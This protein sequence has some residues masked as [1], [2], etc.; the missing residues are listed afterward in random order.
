MLGT[1]PY[2]GSSRLEITEY[3][4]VWIRKDSSNSSHTEG[5]FSDEPLSK[6][7]PPA[8]GSRRAGRLL[9]RFLTVSSAPYLFSINFR[10]ARNGWPAIFSAWLPVLLFLGLLMVESSAAFGSDHTSRPLHSALHS[11]AGSSADKNWTRIHHL[12]RKA[13][14]LVGYGMLS[15][16]LLRAVRMSFGI[17]TKRIGFGV[18]AQLAAIGTTFLVGGLDEWHQAFLPNRTGKF[19]DVLLDTV[20]AAAAQIVLY[21]AAWAVTFYGTYALRQTA[22]Q[23]LPLYSGRGATCHCNGLS[24]L[25]PA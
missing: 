12:I 6:H 2:Y 15:I 24:L 1:V 8:E 13:G 10:P 25:P 21:L 9:R 4:C 7:E 3:D 17:F 11:L 22:Q 19:E 23:T 18:A 5:C 20:G 14:H 16:V